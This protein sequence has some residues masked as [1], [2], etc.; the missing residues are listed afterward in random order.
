[1]E[2]TQAE[3]IRDSIRRGVADEIIEMINQLQPPYDTKPSIIQ[4]INDKYCD[5]RAG[6]PEPQNTSE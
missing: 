1:M 4:A 5:L 2:K 6:Q 3:I